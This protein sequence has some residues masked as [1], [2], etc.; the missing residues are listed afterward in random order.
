MCVALPMKIE[1]IEGTEAVCDAGG[2]KR[3]IRVDLV[4]QAAVGDYILSHAG[5]AIEVLE[6]QRAEENLAALREVLHA[7]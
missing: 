6:E 7:I 5:F 3:R 2:V 4:P 1:S